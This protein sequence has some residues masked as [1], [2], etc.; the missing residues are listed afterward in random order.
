M[1]QQLSVFIENREGRA[2]EMARLLGDAGHNMHALMIA[3]TAEFGVARILCD[4]PLTARETL[5]KAGF[6]VSLT[7]VVAVE[8][9]DRPGALADVLELL[10]REKLNVEYAY[11]FVEPAGGKAAN[12]FRIEDADR[13]SSV[14][15][16]A[17]F[18]ALAAGDIYEVDEL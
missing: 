4:R 11:A 13:A 1:I 8:V 10:S 2:A 16:R 5:R 18:R 15:A 14:L 12:V 17:G 7:R 6:G 9:P 3:D